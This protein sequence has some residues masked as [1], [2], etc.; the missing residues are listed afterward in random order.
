MNEPLFSVL[1]PENWKESTKTRHKIQ[2]YV[3][4]WVKVRKHGVTEPPMQWSEKKDTNTKYFIHWKKSDK[5]SPMI[6]GAPQGVD[7]VA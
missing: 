1:I 3:P 4:I 6:G 2:K 7:P 5:N